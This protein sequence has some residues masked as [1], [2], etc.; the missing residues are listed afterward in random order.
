MTAEM[1]LLHCRCNTTMPHIDTALFAQ[2]FLALANQ[3]CRNQ[4]GKQFLT[5]GKAIP[6][7]AVC[8]RGTA[9]GTPRFEL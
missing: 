9:G 8:A 6:T 3:L 4:K 5:L 2:C 1:L 7:R